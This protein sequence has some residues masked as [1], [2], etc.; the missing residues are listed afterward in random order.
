M[1]S[2][3][4]KGVQIFVLVVL[5]KAAGTDMIAKIQFGK[6]SNKNADSTCSSH[7]LHFLQTGF[8]ELFSEQLNTLCPIIFDIENLDYKI[9]I[10]PCRNVPEADS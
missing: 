9:I 3:F 1:I 2:H 4:C 6:H 5:N 8:D 10:Q 7:A